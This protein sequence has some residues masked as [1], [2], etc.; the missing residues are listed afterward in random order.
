MAGPGDTD[1]GA[2]R[3]VGSQ[4]RTDAE[5]DFEMQPGLTIRVESDDGGGGTYQESLIITVIDENDPPTA[6]PCPQA[7]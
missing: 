6:G 3:V 1:N 4:L 7:R 2:F 5:F